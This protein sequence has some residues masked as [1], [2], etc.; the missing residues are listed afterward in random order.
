M[1]ILTFDV[2]EWFHIL[3]HKSTQNEKQWL[4]F[5]SRI[6]MNMERIFNF[7]QKNEIKATFFVV[8]WIAKKYPEIVKKIDQYGYEIGSH[9]HMHQLM[10]SQ[11][12]NQV[13]QDLIKSIKI[14]QDITGKRINCFRAPGFSIT[15]NNKWIFEILHE[16][17]ITHDSSIFPA[18]RAHGGMSEYKYSKPSK[19][20]YNGL[21]L[22]EFPIN[23][24]SLFGKKIIFS[25][26][27]YFRIMPY[28]LIKKW[29]KNSDYIMTYFHP[30]DFDFN[31]PTIKDLSFFRKFKTYVGIKS[32]MSK[33]NKWVHDYD[34]IDL[35]TGDSMI[36]WS[37]SDTVYL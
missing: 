25:G 5:E 37:K 8:G 17:G 21:F 9:T 11:S 1:N 33:L 30:R 27:G 6:H 24:I 36:D 26:G 4:S 23:S 34:F 31:Q 20:S 22:K 32:C 3:D 28:F 7:L 19:L 35:K 2:E 12:S 14:L 29:S 13:T 18:G 16:N 10:Y 15:Q